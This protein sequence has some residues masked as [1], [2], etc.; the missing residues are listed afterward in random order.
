MGDGFPFM[1]FAVHL[2][3]ASSILGSINIIVTILNMRAP[4]MTLMKMPLF[5]WTWSDHRVPADRCRCRCWRARS[6][7]C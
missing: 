7:C 4:G 2:S 3:G 6:P 5:V 1:I